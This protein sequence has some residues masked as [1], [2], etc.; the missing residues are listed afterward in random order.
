MIRRKIVLFRLDFQ[1]PAAVDWVLMVD[2]SLVAA[3]VREKA[4]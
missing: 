1:I 2:V 3:A 4:L